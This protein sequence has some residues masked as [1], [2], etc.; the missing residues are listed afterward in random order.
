MTRSRSVGIRLDVLGKPEVVAALREVGAAGGRLADQIEK[1]GPRAGA[2]LKAIDGAAEG[3]RGRLQGIADEA[4]GFGRALGALGPAGRAAGVALGALTLGLGAAIAKGREAVRGFA[5]LGDQADRLGVTAEALQRL[6]Y[7]AAQVGVSEGD[8]IADL[9][10]EI[11]DRAAQAQI[12]SGEAADAF[13]ALGVSVV[14]AAGNL[15]PVETLVL[16]I[17]D[18]F[19]QLDSSVE[20]VSLASSLMGDEGRRLIPLLERGSGAV[21][22]YGDEA[23]RTGAIVENDFV[24]QSQDLNVAL[25]NQW[26]VIDT[27]LSKGMAALAPIIG[28]VLEAVVPLIAKVVE[29]TEA[30]RSLDRQQDI[31]LQNAAEALRSQITADAARLEGGS[32]GG[33]NKSSVTDRLDRMRG[34]LAAIEAELR[35]RE[36][37]RSRTPPAS[38][39]PSAPGMAAVAAAAEAERAAAS[40]PKE[41]ERGIESMRPPV[42]RGMTR[43]EY[44][45]WIKTQKDLQREA[46]RSADKL[47]DLADRGIGDAMQ[48][49]ADFATGLQ[50]GADLLRSFASDLARDLPALLGGGEVSTG[51][52]GILKSAFDLSD[53]GIL[54]ETGIKAAAKEAASGI[55]AWLTGLPGLASGGGFDVTPASSIGIRPQGGDDRLVSFRARLGERVQVTPPGGGGRIGDVNFHLY[56]DG[57]TSEATI[58]RTRQMMRE[59]IARAEPL[60][61]GRAVSATETMIRKDP[62]FGR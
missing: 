34:E 43:D 31:T 22:N 24:R 29:L 30:W 9:L 18:G 62:G 53:D 33:R 44:D 16:D 17:A 1:A 58:E 52:G 40:A 8:T 38:A 55:G 26:R 54:A 10:G 7:A 27:Q 32:L 61:T 4:G 11:S 60:L 28:D 23:E 13:K 25:E 19:S 49:L 21:R 2:G 46:E 14:D 20:K 12:G 39:T 37:R 42:P 41:D 6:Q 59:E 45:A 35:A 36:E 51:I 3:L 48:G 57:E 5:E 15:K 56:V 50:D 47:Q